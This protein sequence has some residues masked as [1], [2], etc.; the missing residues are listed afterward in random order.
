VRRVGAGRVGLGVACGLIAAML[1]ACD[2]WDRHFA[3]QAAVN[4]PGRILYLTYCESCHGLGGAG[5]GP[6]AS[7][8]RTPPADLTRLWKRY[9]T[10]LDRQ[11]LA[12]YI[13]GRQLMYSHGRGEMPIWGDEFFAD[14]PP[15][16][17]NLEA[18]R[19]RLI[20]VLVEY[21]ETLQT[22]QRS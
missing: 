3:A 4:S 22:E 15:A 5:D 9:G 14:A 16:T 11:R 19:R 10:P 20:E 17:P 18:T 13:D 1:A 6:A 21:L 8:L 2:A 7:S 12:G